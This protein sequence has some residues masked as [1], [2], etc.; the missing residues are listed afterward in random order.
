M[1]SKLFDSE[2]SKRQE[3]RMDGT[4][5]DFPSVVREIF[6]HLG[7]EVNDEIVDTLHRERILSKS[8]PFNPI[9][10]DI[11]KMLEQIKGVGMKTCLISNCTPEEVTAWHTSA[12]APYFDDAIFSYEVKAAKPN[13]LIY[14]LA[15]ER[16]GVSP[17]ESV[18]I[19]DGGSNELEGAATVGM[20]VYHATWFIPPFISEKITGYFKLT[21]PSEFIAL[22]KG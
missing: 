9:D 13:P 5:P 16:M 14:H 11:L 6:S 12:L 8:I 15:C 2:W 19:G 20:S 4:Y 18:F 1:D 10:Y 3:K 7:F 22:L 17:F 21:K